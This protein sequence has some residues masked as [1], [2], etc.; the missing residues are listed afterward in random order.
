M[1]LLP[2]RICLVRRG[3]QGV[4]ESGD[5]VI[6]LPRPA[7]DPLSC[8]GSP[9]VQD[10]RGWLQQV[11]Q[12]AELDILR[13][14]PGHEPLPDCEYAEG[15]KHSAAGFV[16]RR[17]RGRRGHHRSIL[18]LLSAVC[19]LQVVQRQPRDK[20]DSACSRR[21]PV[22]RSVAALLGSEP[23]E[24]SPHLGP[25]SPGECVLVAG[26]H[27]L[28]RDRRYVVLHVQVWPEPK[29]QQDADERSQ[30]GLL[31]R[32]VEQHARHRAGG[33]SL[34][35]CGFRRVVCLGSGPGANILQRP[36]V[37]NAVEVPV[38]QVQSRRAL[39]GHSLR[40][41]G[42][43]AQ[44]RLP[45]PGDGQHPADMGSADKYR[46]LVGDCGVSTVAAHNAEPAGSH[47]A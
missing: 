14:V 33:C 20:S 23:H 38:H 4:L 29:R 22:C 31:R 37:A 40:C 30:H 8:D 1:R 32:G 10:V 42:G 9:P 27:V 46:L 44:R 13:R 15:L 47:D 3:V 43:A 39:V 7:S 21:P 45:V 24:Q 25:Q 12:V 28:R 18:H 26:V 19:R 6:C 17:F 36:W 11:E 35:G 2:R 34:L 5:D 16:S 41:E